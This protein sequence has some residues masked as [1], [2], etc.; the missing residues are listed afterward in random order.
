[1]YRYV[2]QKT[3]NYCFKFE[4][5]KCSIPAKQVVAKVLSRLP[6]ENA[7]TRLA[8]KNSTYRTN[9]FREPLKNTHF[10]RQSL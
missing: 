8:A 4:C 6:F 3:A 5:T 9:R 10:E 2:F 7:E 1:M